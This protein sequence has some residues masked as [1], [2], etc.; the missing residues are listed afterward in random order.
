MRNLQDDKINFVIQKR[1]GT[2]RKPPWKRVRAQKKFY[3]FQQL[4]K[5]IVIPSFA[6]IKT[7][8]L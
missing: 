3:P 8:I 7:K 1:K 5:R 4:V 6:A 2:P